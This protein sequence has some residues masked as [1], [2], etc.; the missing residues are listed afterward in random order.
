MF[1]QAPHPSFDGFD[2]WGNY[3][4]GFAEVENY[5]LCR[6]ITNGIKDFCRIY[7]EW[8]G[9]YDFMFN[10]SGYDAYIPFRG[11]KRNYDV[12][13]S[14]VGEYKFQQG[15]GIDLSKQ[16]VK[17]LEELIEEKRRK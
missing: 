14:A 4:F 10:I 17:T 11:M 6:E 7:I 2:A 15:V 13:I 3:M 5:D 16:T 1:T 12:P 8:Y 9:E